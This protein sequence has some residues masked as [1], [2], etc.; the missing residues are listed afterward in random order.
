[1]VVSA[2]RDSEKSRI[3]LGGANE[4]LVLTARLPLESLA[5]MTAI[6][7]APFDIRMPTLKTYVL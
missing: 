2:Q 6:A 5:P 4:A 7:A 3:P 1:M